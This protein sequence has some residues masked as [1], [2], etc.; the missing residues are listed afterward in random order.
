MKKILLYMTDF[1]FYNNVIINEIKKKGFDVTW[2]QDKV[3]LN[4]FERF[5]S[6]LFKCYKQ[7]KFNLYFQKTIAKT[8]E[9]NFEK[10]IIIFGGNF[11][12]DKHIKILKKTFPKTPIIYYAW[13]S[14]SNFPKIKKLFSNCD[15]S[16]SFDYYDSKKYNVNFLPL[17]YIEDKSVLQKKYDVS[18]IMSYYVEKN[19]NLELFLNKLPNNLNKFFYFKIRDKL[20]LNRIKKEN[21]NFYNNYKKYFHF[22]SLSLEQCKNVFMSSKAV[23][24]TPLPLQ[25]GLTMRTLEVLSSKTKLITT[26]DFIEN[27]NF[28]NKNNI[29]IIKKGSCIVP[30]DFLNSDFDSLGKIPKEYSISTF[31]DILLGNVELNEEVY[32]KKRYEGDYDETIK[33][34]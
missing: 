28:Y 17:F 31:V 33:F 19:K 18:I 30:E 25:S 22:D 29:Y 6:K 14:V 9:N 26:N 8:K 24:D 1:Y 15:I 27:Y 5:F 16:Y 23:I 7:K 34:R 2:F 11:F 10:I 21:K 12:L 32:L 20:Y 4:N 3:S 13:D